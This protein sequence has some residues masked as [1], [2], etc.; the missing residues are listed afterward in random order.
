MKIQEQQHINR[1]FYN[2]HVHIYIG[3]QLRFHARKLV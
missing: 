1:G 3:V 2:S